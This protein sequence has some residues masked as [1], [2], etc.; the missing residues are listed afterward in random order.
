M[1]APSLLC[2]VVSAGTSRFDDCPVCGTERLAT[3]MHGLGPA[4]TLRIGLMTSCG[5]GD[6]WHCAF[7][8]AVLPMDGRAAFRHIADTHA[9]SD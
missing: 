6:R 8:P 1:N 3:E 5:C 2:T 4:G 7:C 9:A